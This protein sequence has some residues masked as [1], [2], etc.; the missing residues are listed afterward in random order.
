M[1]HTVV[2]ARGSCLVLLVQ[3]SSYNL[4]TLWLLCYFVRT[5][6]LNIKWHYE[7][8]KLYSNSY[9]CQ[10]N[11]RTCDFKFKNMWF[12]TILKFLP[13]R[14]VNIGYLSRIADLL[15]LFHIF[16]KIFFIFVFGVQ[17]ISWCFSFKES[18]CFLQATRSHG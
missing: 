10:I 5:K 4:S 6:M 12:Y 3:C 7:C 1:F 13:H 15:Q 14:C 2:V 11:L 17:W 18:R 8:L 9:I 16:L